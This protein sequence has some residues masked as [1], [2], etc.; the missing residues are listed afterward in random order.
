M[1]IALDPSDA[2]VEIFFYFDFLHPPTGFLRAPLCLFF[3]SFCA[4]IFPGQIA[5]LLSRFSLFLFQA[6]NLNAERVFLLFFSH[7]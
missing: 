1:G 7:N 4:F 6:G 2:E 3:F 5:R